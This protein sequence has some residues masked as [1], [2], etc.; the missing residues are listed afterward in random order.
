MSDQPRENENRFQV[1]RSGRPSPRRG[2]RAMKLPRHLFVSWWHAHAWAGVL[3]GLVLAAMFLG[4]AFS[5]FR[6]PLETWQDPPTAAA[7][8]AAIDRVA[9]ARLAERS[10]AG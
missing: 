9:Q 7:D 6:R 5:L 1:P 2:W 4:G 3:A 10:V 8:R